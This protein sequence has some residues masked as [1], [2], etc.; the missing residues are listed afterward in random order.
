M[1]RNKRKSNATTGNAATLEASTSHDNNANITKNAK[2]KR[3]SQSNSKQ[4]SQ[5]LQCVKSE[6]TAVN[7]SNRER[8]K[9][10]RYNMSQV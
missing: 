7:N 5:H 2:S 8:E 10:Q 9:T 4:R 3:S 6:T 1:I